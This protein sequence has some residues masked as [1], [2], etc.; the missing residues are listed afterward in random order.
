MPMKFKEFLELCEKVKLSRS[1][2]KKTKKDLTA[3]RRYSAYQHSEF[4]DSPT[5]KSTHVSRSATQSP[6]DRG[7]NGRRSV[8]DGIAAKEK[9]AK[10]REK[11]G[12]KKIMKLNFRKSKKKK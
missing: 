8:K 5:H 12:I 4:G 11:E 9:D 1:E 6:L 3:V 7:A 10:K 2:W